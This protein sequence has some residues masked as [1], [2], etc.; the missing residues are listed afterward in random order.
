VRTN[1]HTHCD[2]C[3]GRASAAVMAEA[4]AA[5]GY[6]V[7]G[8]SSHGPL[9]FPSEGNIGLSRLGEYRD[10]IRALGRAWEG[11]GLEILL[12]LEVDYV[13]GLCSPR[14]EFFAAFGFDYLLGSAHYI[15]LPG[16]GRFAVD[17]CEEDFLER[18]TRYPGADPGRAVY[19]A[20]YREL[21]ALIEEGGFDILGHFDLVRKN[22]DAGADGIG[23]WFDEGSRGYLDAALGA[24]RL[25][26]GK[27]I[28]AEVNVGG[29]SR[30]KVKSPY[31]SLPILKE[32]RAAGVRITFSADAHAPEHFGANLDAAR[33]L[34]RAAGYDSVAVLTKGKWIEV[35]IDET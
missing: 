18:I 22:N 29:I 5:A 21:S 35:G 4:A 13:R 27:D 8:F 26:E 11:R 24:A 12:G 7:L 16:S 28:V 25:L 31:P 19:V 9:P 23:R 30:G 20:Y 15:D 1:Y 3:D 33:E 34:S 17:Y 32:L 10:E 2:Y 6:S 14:D